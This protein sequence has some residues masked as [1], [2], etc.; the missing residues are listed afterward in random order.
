VCHVAPATCTPRDKQTRFFKRNKD[1]GK[2]R[3]VMDSNSNIAKLMTHHN[4]T[5]ELTTWLLNLPL[6]ESID[7]KKHKVW[8]SN[9]KPHEA[10]LEDQKAKKSSKGL[11]RRR[12][13]HKT[14]K[15]HKK[16]QTKQN[17]KEEPRKAQ[18]KKTQNSSW[19]QVPLTLSV[20]ALPLR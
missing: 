18:N 16:W 2:N 12:K 9:P 6:D 14:N 3:N 20:H 5:K 13:G 17:D 19:N 1:K 4:Q 11:S 15:R 10:Q 8:C 7:N